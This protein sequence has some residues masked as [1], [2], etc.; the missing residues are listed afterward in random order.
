[1]YYDYP[2]VSWVN[3][4]LHRKRWEGIVSRIDQGESI[5]DLI[6][7]SGD[8]KHLQKMIKEEGTK[9]F[10]QTNRPIV[11]VILNSID[12]RGDDQ[13]E[14]AVHI[15]GRKNSVTIQDQGESMELEDVLRYLIIPFSTG[16]DTDNGREYIG[17]FGLGFFGTFGYCL[18]DPDHASVVIRTSKNQRSWEGKFYATEKATSA[19]R[20]RLASRR[21]RGQGTLVSINKPG[22]D[23]KQLKGYL[24]SQ[25]GNIPS[26]QAEIFYNDKQLNDDTNLWHT[27]RYRYERRDGKAGIATVGLQSTNDQKIHLTSMGVNVKSY[28]SPIKDGLKVFF[29]GSVNIVIGRDEL[30]RDKI[31]YSAARAS[32]F[33][34]QEMAMSEKYKPQSFTDLVPSLLGAVSL[35]GLKDIPNLKFWTDTLLKGRQYVMVPNEYSSLQHFVSKKKELLFYCS[36]QNS[37]VWGEIYKSC[38]DFYQDHFKFHQSL[39]WKQFLLKIWSDFKYLPNLRLLFKKHDE[40]SKTKYSNVHLVSFSPVGF[41]YMFRRTRNDLYINVDHRYIRAQPNSLC[42]NALIALYLTQSHVRPKD[43]DAQYIEKILMQLKGEMTA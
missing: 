38:E 43:A 20:L 22:F 39:P 15:T 13:D 21:C 33:A 10:S 7:N 12:A 3:A 23:L 4:C 30:I 1:M 29:P 32:F 41:P 9:Q 34:L 6:E 16:K 11:E 26:M 40:L 28:I 5:D 24:Q 37:S 8:T 25:V 35:S 19:L 14:Y 27:V 42:A 2:L 31:Y 17:R 36:P 18:R